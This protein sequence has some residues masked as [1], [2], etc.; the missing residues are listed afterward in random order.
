MEREKDEIGEDRIGE[1]RR[2]KNGK[3]KKREERRG[4]GRGEKITH[5][6]IYFSI[7]IL[8]QTVRI[9]NL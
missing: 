7:L 6:F 9:R 3:E 5:S 1:T 8:L 2:G 4:R